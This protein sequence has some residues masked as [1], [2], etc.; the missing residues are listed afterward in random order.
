MNVKIMLSINYLSFS[1]EAPISKY[2][3]T[4]YSYAKNATQLQWN[5]TLWSVEINHQTFLN[6]LQIHSSD[7]TVWER[8]FYR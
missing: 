4:D 7:N 5:E 2:P 3:N 6:G 1:T 8:I